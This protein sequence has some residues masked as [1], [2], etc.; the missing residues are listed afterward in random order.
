MGI[1]DS[2]QFGDTEQGGLI[3]R[4]RQII[5]AA[6]TNVG[7][8]FSASPLNAQA[9]VP[10]PQS[11]AP[12]NAPIAI[13]DYQMPRIGSGFLD[14][15]P[16]HD[17]AT[18]E[19]IQPGQAPV[20]IAPAPQPAA[21]NPLLKMAA[22]LHNIANGSS[23]YGAVTGNPDDA[24]STQQRQLQQQQNAYAGMG[25]SPQEATGMA[26]NPEFAKAL[27]AQ[28][29]GP[30]AVQNLGQGY[31]ADKN[32]KITRA[33]TPEQ[34]DNFVTVQTGEDGLGRKT[35]S[36][37]NKATG[38]MTPIA[39]GPGG[40]E[41][42]SS[43]LGDMTKTGAEYLATLPPDLAGRVKAMVEGRQPPPSSL[44]QTRPYW[45][46][47]ISAAQTYD[48]TF[49]ATNWSG[50][51]AGVKDFS[52]GKSAEM[53]R[54][55][56]QTLHHV[57][58]LLTSM[59]DLKNGNYPL[60]NRIGNAASEA[61]GSGAQGAFRTN[62]HAVAE[63][64]SK[65]FK[66]ANLSD[67]EIHAWEQNLH[68]NMSPEQQRMQ[69]AKLRDLLAG[70]LHALEEKRLASIGPMAAEKAGPLIREEGQ[71]VLKRIDDWIKAGT[72]AASGTAPTG[73]KWSV[74]K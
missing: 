72:G 17:A 25:F 29:F 74:V 40:A 4:L 10:V 66:G 38:T 62:A 69:I 2:Y 63:E 22:G 70:S 51:V 13:G 8:G 61:K 42:N 53:V 26:I 30:Q 11:V 23:I 6:P 14:A 49:D 65:V 52:A 68:E 71:H 33:Y 41:P 56:N 18:G 64:L 16:A 43:G 54:S 50:R 60:W 15:Y 46:N 48:P 12:Q 58:Q 37:M 31:V 67:A 57:G 36:K 1:F 24:K 21:P 5:D 3:D 55:A 39:S 44:A 9:S 28:K 47:L 73:V 19:T 20:A 35:F 7:P 32:G 45:Q 59:D 34:N 27:I